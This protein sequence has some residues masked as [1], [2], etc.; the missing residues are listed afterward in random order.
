MRAIVRYHPDTHLLFAEPAK[1][2]RSLLD[3]LIGDFRSYKENDELPDY[4]GRDAPYIQ[5]AAAYKARLMHMHINPAGFP[6]R[7]P[8][9][10]RTSDIALVYVQGEIEENHFCLLALF[11]P[12]AHAKARD[13]KLMQWLSRLAQKFRDQY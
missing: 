12:D 10:D 1:P 6:R 2:F 11:N 5:P 3:H 7:L 4:F 13:E 8:Q 9:M